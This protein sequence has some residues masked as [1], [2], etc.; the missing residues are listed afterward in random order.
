[1]QAERIASY[2]REF[3]ALAELQ[4]AGAVTYSLLRGAD[5]FCIC[6]QQDGAQPVMRTLR[7]TGEERART[8]IRFLYEN[9]VEPA[10][11]P[12]VLQD[13]CGTAVG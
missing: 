9:A 2:R 12:A 13:L 4:D 7:G 6:V 8:L 1:M 11:V 5:S 10:Q 3:S